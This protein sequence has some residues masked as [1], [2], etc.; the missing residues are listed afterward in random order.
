[1]PLYDYECFECG[2][3][4]EDLANPDDMSMR[5]CRRDGCPGLC[6]RLVSYG[7]GANVFRDEAPWISSV[8]QVVAKDSKNPEARAFIETPNRA[9]YVKWMKS[10]GLR[11]YEPGENRSAREHKRQRDREF[12]ANHA[13]SVMRAWQNGKRIEI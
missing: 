8:L 13:E 5:P 9:N 10:E 6:E 11:P 2:S 12:D 4:F 3:V 7:R 1:M